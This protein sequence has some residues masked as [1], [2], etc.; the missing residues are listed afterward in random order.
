MHEIN[1]LKNNTYAVAPVIMIW[2]RMDTF[3]VD[4]GYFWGVTL[5]AISSLLFIIAM[6]KLRKIYIA[7]LASL[8]FGLNILKTL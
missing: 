5:V 6:R 4:I 8:I 3:Q 7:D 1:P 2:N